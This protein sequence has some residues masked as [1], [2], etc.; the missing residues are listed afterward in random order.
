MTNATKAQII[1]ALNAILGVVVAFGVDLSDKQLGAVMF[2][3]NAV[4]SLVVG[5]TFKNSAKRIPEK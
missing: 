3:A 5:L 1:A 4:L 2:A